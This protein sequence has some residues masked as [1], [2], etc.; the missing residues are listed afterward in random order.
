MAQPIPQRSIPL[1][2]LNSRLYDAKVS[3]GEMNMKDSSTPANV[4]SEQ[5]H[6]ILTMR[7]QDCMIVWSRELKLSTLSK[8]YSGSIFSGVTR[9]HQECATEN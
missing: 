4:K 8:V 5:S 9:N 2:A 3:F 6:A 7:N 1:D